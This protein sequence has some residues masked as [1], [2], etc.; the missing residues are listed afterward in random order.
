M[1][2]SFGGLYRLVF[3][4]WRIDELYAA[5]IVRPL[6]NGSR[7]VL[8]AIVDQR[9]IDFAVNLVGILAKIGSYAL[10][11]FQTG[12]VQAYAFVILVGLV[13]I[14]FLGLRPF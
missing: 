6:V 11:F 3:D 12:Y 14:V 8:F 2:Q 7:K 1:A 9:V 4:K 10:R 5:A 13:V